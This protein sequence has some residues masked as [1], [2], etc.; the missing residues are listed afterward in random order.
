MNVLRRFPIA[1]F[2]L[3]LWTMITFFATRGEVTLLVT[4]GAI[5]AMSWYISQGPRGRALPKSIAS[6]FILAA[7]VSVVPDIAANRDDVIGVIGRF[8]VWLCLIKLY[9]RKTHVDYGQLLG[10]S[11]LLMIAGLLQTRDLLFGLALLGYTILGTY[12]LLLYQFYAANEKAQDHRLTDA[13]HGARLIP[14]SRPVL[15]RGIKGQFIAMGIGLAIVGLLVT[16]IIFAAYPRGI[17]SGMIQAMLKQPERNRTGFVDQVSLMTG[18]RITESRTP[19][20]ELRLLNNVGEGVEYGEPL[21][22]RG[23]ALEWYDT[24]TYT[25]KLSPASTRKTISLSAGSR[26]FAPLVPPQSPFEIENS[27]TQYKLEFAPLSAMGDVVFTLAT[28]VGVSFDA[29]REVTFNQQTHAIRTKGS[30]TGRYRVLSDPFPDRATLG[31]ITNGIPLT[32]SGNLRYTNPPIDALARQILREAGVPLSPPAGYP[33]RGRHNQRVARAFSDYLT[34][35]F[36]YTLDLSDVSISGD[37]IEAFLFQFKKGHCEYFASAMVAMCQLVDVE[38]RL[39]TGFLGV[40]YEEDGYYRIREGNAHAWVEVRAGAYGW[41]TFD[42]TPPSVMDTMQ[43]PAE[44]IATQVRGLYEMFESE[45]IQGMVDYDSTAQSNLQESLTIGSIEWLED[46]MLAISDWV[47]RFVNRFGAAG[48]LQIL[49]VSAAVAVAILVVIQLIRRA[50]R[51]RKALHLEGV[52]G[53]E[54]RRILRQLGFY[55]DML[56]TLKR[57]GQPKPHWQPPLAFAANIAEG[58]N[59]QAADSVRFL[60]DLFYQAR[61]GGRRLSNEEIATAN[62]E[63]ES[64]ETALAQKS[65]A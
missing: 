25:W 41:E 9:E 39:V 35:N 56:D 65:S 45:W 7:A 30:R 19:V 12:V 46:T 63:L 34:S 32:L 29:T 14:S 51:I 31:A 55:V 37:P 18:S 5:A 4:T 36:I 60:A 52:T 48:W 1:A 42:P 17:G 24:S 15:G 27:A 62:L 50:R 10:L 57:G 13:P 3:V 28:P 21:Y 8:A 61:F 2:A 43:Q 20:F 26:R 6:L 47:G 58:G 22:L 40:E 33:E 49:V 44:G 16:I 64:L 23:A 53:P 54:Y 11:L 38:A 59:V